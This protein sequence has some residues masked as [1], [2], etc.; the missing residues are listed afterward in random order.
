MA[1]CQ[2]GGRDGHRR[3]GEADQ[4]R[5]RPFARSCTIT[6]TAIVAT[7]IQVPRGWCRRDG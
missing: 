1:R 3:E 5:G 4:E 2:A 6:T 7:P